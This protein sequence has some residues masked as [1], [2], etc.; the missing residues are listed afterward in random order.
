MMRLPFHHKKWNGYVDSRNEESGRGGQGKKIKLGRKETR[1]RTGTRSKEI[2]SF[3][4]PEVSGFGNK[5]GLITIEGEGSETRERME[6]GD[7]RRGLG[8]EVQ[9]PK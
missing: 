6:E 7:I 2:H 9:V 5:L 4:E 1:S 3:M 8:E